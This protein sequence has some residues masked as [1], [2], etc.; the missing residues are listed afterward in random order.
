MNER[1]LGSAFAFVRLAI[2]GV[3]LLAPGV[4]SRWIGPRAGEP[5]V[6]TL[7]RSLG[8]RDVALGAG[9]LAA[10]DRGEAAGPWLRAGVVADA[11]D[12]VATLVALRHLP[13]AGALAA[14]AAAGGGVLVGTRLLRS[15][16]D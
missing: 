6:K 9:L 5:P 14:A 4:V 11:T 2:G 7:T 12:L 8:A 10:L 13:R 3:V 1:S 15:P 16:G